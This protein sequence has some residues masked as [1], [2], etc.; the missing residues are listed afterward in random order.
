[1][2]TKDDDSYVPR[3]KIEKKNA[4]TTRESIVRFDRTETQ[5]CILDNELS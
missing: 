5:R 4:T 2:E 1:M 3:S